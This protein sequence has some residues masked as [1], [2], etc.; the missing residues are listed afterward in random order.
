MRN[1]FRSKPRVNPTRTVIIKHDGKSESTEQVPGE[2]I[3][4]S[5]TRQSFTQQ[6]TS[7]GFTSP[8]GRF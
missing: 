5:I 7:R 6:A 2:V 4:L 8:P 3:D 1:P